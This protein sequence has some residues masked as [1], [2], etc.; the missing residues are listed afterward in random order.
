MDPIQSLLQAFRML[1]SAAVP[2]GAFAVVGNEIWV[3]S[4]HAYGA[5]LV[6]LQLYKSQQV[7]MRELDSRKFDSVALLL[8][9]LVGKRIVTDSGMHIVVSGPYVPHNAMD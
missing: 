7:Y 4:T 9:H 2:T 1:M 6:K 3:K 5:T 8:H